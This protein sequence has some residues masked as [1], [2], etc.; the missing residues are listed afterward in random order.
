MNYTDDLT[1]DGQRLLGAKETMQY[2]NNM[3]KTTF[4]RNI[5]RGHIPAPRYM[6]CTPLWQ[7]GDLRRVYEN[8]P[9]EPASERLT[10]GRG[11]RLSTKILS[12]P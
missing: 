2:L 3:P 9:S 4:Y 5:K 8:L 10:A 11:N 1:N 6:G 12:T 7:L